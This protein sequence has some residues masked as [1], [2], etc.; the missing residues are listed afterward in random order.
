MPDLKQFKDW[1]Q[2][3]TDSP[4][5]IIRQYERGFAGCKYDP[6]SVE[7]MRT[8]GFVCAEDA[9]HEYGYAGSA[10]NELTLPY[11][12]VT[13]RYPNAY[14]GPAQ[15]RGSCV[16]HAARNAALIT[17]AGE[18][19]AGL[20]DE[21][22]GHT[23][24]F[25]EVPP[26]GEVNGVLAIEPLYW[27]RGHSDDG[28]YCAAA[29]NAMVKH[30]GAVVR[31]QYPEVDLTKL[32]PTL[33]GKYWQ[34]SQIPDAVYEACNDNLFRDAA[35]VTD[36]DAIRDL[37]ARGIGINSC[38][39]EGFSNKRN[40]DGVSE[41]QG[42]WAHAMAIVGYDDRPDTHAKYGGPLLLVQNSWGQWNTGPRTV[43]GTEFQIPEG[44]FWARWRDVRKR[45]YVAI[46]GLNGWR[47]RKLPDYSAGW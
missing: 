9:L 47:R 29:G 10:R 7:E 26:D 28:W 40:A 38:G 12:A 32:D 20:P 21:A 34:R 15:R 6:A 31:K 14:P 17:L 13:G 25:P 8:Y 24:D 45:S 4:A 27:H 23:E 37:L 22:S 39:S 5:D 3:A 41:R 46:A 44:C 43:R 1:Q 42:S 16:A 33:A 18:V 19:V 36:P 11:L 35:E 2:P 30:T